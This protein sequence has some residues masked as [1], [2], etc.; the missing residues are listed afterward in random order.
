MR[1]GVARMQVRLG[2]IVKLAAN[3]ATTK[4]IG[5]IVQRNI[6]AAHYAP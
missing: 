5:P 3:A 6:E 4:P 2:H 1:G